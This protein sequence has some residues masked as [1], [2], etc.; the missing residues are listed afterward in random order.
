[1]S[2]APAP[3]QIAA[4]S[5]PAPLDIARYEKPGFSVKNEDGRLWIFRAGSKEL[6]DFVAVGEPA[7]QVV[8]PGALDGVT[9]K[10]VDS[11]T[12]DEYIATIPGFVVRARDGRMWVFKADSAELA[13]FEATGEPARQVIRPGAGPMGVTL[14]SSDSQVID[15]YLAAYQ[16]Q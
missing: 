5:E 2:E 3:E 13:E 11:E 12:I 9:V 1:V 16:S 4:P 7:R 6:A 8:R 15:D 10:S 14:K